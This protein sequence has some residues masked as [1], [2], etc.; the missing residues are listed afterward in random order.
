MTAQTAPATAGPAS[1][2]ADARLSGV[3]I[4][5]SEWVKLVTLRSTWWCLGVIVALTAGIPLLIAG[6]LTAASNPGANP[7]ADSGYY[8]WMMATTLPIGFSVLAAAVLGCLV[9]T[10]EYGTGMIRSTMTAAP[11]RVSALLAKAL[12]IGA[13]IFVVVLVSL[14][15]GAVLSGLVFSGAGFVVDPADGRVWLTILA[16]A[17]YPAL[18]AVFSVGVGAVLRNSAGAIASVLG[19]LLVVPTILQLVGGLLRAEWAFNVGAFLPSSLGATM[20]TPVLDGMTNT[21][22]TVSLEPWSAALAMAGWAVAALL[23]GTL[24]I[25]RRD[26]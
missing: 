13:T 24:L 7:D 17:G 10:G 20:Y 9:I 6:A 5:R 21:L 23:G 26:V 15:I 19:L 1:G 16:A 2:L 12:V 14:A 18:I 22:A 8:N 4:I 11:K 3:G 25:T